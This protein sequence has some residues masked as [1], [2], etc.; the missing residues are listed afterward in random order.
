[1]ER[2]LSI[3]KQ[4]LPIA[5]VAAILCCLVYAAVQQALR[6][7]ADDPQIQMAEDAASAFAAG[8]APQALLPAAQIDI[9]KSLAPFFIFFD[10]A[11]KPVASSASLHGE[12][13]SPPV[14]VFEYV[15]SHGEERVT[16]QPEPGVRIA[17]VIVRVNGPV[18]GF[19]L[20][21]RSLREVEKREARLMSEAAAALL[22][23]LG[24]SLAL[25]GFREYQG[26]V[27]S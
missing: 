27:E 20:A 22:F 9:G 3:L 26:K 13:P 11:G 17:S 23:T 25:V 6:E 12:P 2:M 4:W 10:A 7:G 21:G 24:I 16:W 8:S 5:A 19:V 14:G 18:Y 15:R 1:M